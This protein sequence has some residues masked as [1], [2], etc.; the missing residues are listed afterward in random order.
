MVSNPRG[1]V[2]GPMALKVTERMPDGSVY[3]VHGF[4]HRSRRLSRANGKGGDDSAVIDM[5]AVDPISGSTGMRTQFVTVRA[6]RAT[7]VA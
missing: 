1:D 2:T 5:Y 6:A 3:M 7:E 4:G